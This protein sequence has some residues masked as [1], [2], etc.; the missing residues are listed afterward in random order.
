MSGIPEKHTSE[1][2]ASALTLSDGDGGQQATREDDPFVTRPSV[3]APQVDP[4]SSKTAPDP[5]AT[6]LPAPE[7]QSM[8]LQ[9][10]S[11]MRFRILKPHAKGGLGQVFVAHDDELE[12]EVALKEI[13]DRYADDSDSRDRFL[14]EARIT[15]RL[16]HPGIVPV[17]GLGCSLDGRPY[18][19]MRFIRGDSL[20]KAIDSFHQTERPD[21]DPGQRS[22]E[23]HKLLG[24]FI[25]ICNAMAYAHSR[26]ILH[27]DLK[28]ANVMLGHFGETLVVDW[29]LAKILKQ[30]QG[31]AAPTEPLSRPTDTNDETATN[32][33][34]AIG[35]PVFMSPEQ[36]AG[37]LDRLGPASDVYSLGATLYCLLTGRVPFEADDVATIL[38]RVQQADFPPP[39]RVKPG[40]PRALEA[41]CLKAMALRPE[42]RYPTAQALG[43]DVESWMA[44]EPVSAWREPWYTRARRW[45]IRHRTLVTAC[46]TAAGVALVCLVAVVLLV[47]AGRQREQLRLAE[48]RTG[49]QKLIYAGEAAT[50]VQDWQNANLHLTSALAR[51]GAEPE[52]AD[53]KAT[54]ENL[55]EQ[56]LQHLAV[57]A[58]RQQAQEQH[59]RFT[60]MRDEALFQ[61]GTLFTSMDLQ[62]NLLETATAIDDALGLVGVNVADKE[63]VVWNP[64]YSKAELA[65]ITEGCYGLLLILAEVQAQA[66][67]GPEPGKKK[68]AVQ[69]SLRTLD[70]AAQVGT[71]SQAY[72]L[73]RARYLDLLGEAERAQKESERAQA[74]QPVHAVDFFLLGD[75]WYKRGRL[76]E[77]IEAFDRTLRLQPDHFWAQFFLALRYLESQRPAEAKA[78]LTACLSRRPDFPWLYLLRGM[79]HGG[80][81]EFVLAEADFAQALQ[82]NP[83]PEAWYV[84]WIY[85]GG[86]RNRQEKFNEAVADLQQA[87]SLMPDRPQAHESLI[88]AFLRG[89]RLDEAAARLELALRRWP[90]A[91]S[92]RRLHARLALARGDSQGALHD[93]E[94]AIQLQPP[95]CTDLVD[96]HLERGRIFFQDKKYAEAVEACAAVLKLRPDH[97]E[98]CLTQVRALLALH[99][100]KEAAKACDHYLEKGQPVA[101]VFRLR[102]RARSR[103]GDHGA[104]VDDFS[105]CLVAA[106]A[107]L[108]VERGW[109]YFESQAWNLALRDFQGALRLDPENH[110]ALNGRALGYAY[111]GQYREAVKDGEAALRRTPA[112]PVRNYNI[113][114]VYAVAAAKV[115][116]DDKTADRAELAGRYRSRAMELLQASL[117]LRAE[118]DRQSFWRDTVQKD[119]ALES[120]RKE[121][122]Y[123]RLEEQYG[124]PGS[125]PP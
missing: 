28:P 77:A 91:A 36:A 11:N 116:A 73:R 62:A 113:A 80:A 43:A 65:E 34:V 120:I 40:V 47:R 105:R 122:R 93:F 19:A 61:Y 42:N 32:M 51:I 3:A 25:D 69:Q 90:K 99:K 78:S 27:R 123:V 17:Y 112:S 83:N 64:Q 1:P 88:Q 22:L 24:R 95:D 124:R 104:A 8:A 57:L 14:R 66:G 121:P 5:Y 100:S 114:C 72:H 115:A 55:R 46:S 86:M 31:D 75:E 97:T 102:G 54:A 60:K 82:R 39:C 20:E 94:T 110:Y 76:T 81:G 101:E 23:L 70:R 9:A 85:R 7:N 33:G 52:L 48:L 30:P 53:L 71:A 74:L 98:G 119:T 59:Q 37:Q 87:I 58:A 107:D 89:K 79:V 41:V 10:N 50:K 63:P 2:H 67:S 49:A 18:Y 84:L 96:D 103:Q 68:A 109:E 21:C 125:S 92:F 6:R 106:D 108:L 4:L 117:D 118:K 56:T 16:E 35:T 29:G 44:D 15:G 12:R 111:T 38:T 26:N 45:I 13:Q